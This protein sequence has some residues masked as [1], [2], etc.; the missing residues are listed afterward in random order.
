MSGP[1][2]A[3]EKG[4]NDALILGQAEG[5]FLDPNLTLHL[6]IDKVLVEAEESSKYSPKFYELQLKNPI[7]IENELLSP[8]PVCGFQFSFT[9]N[10][11]VVQFF[12]NISPHV[13][14]LCEFVNSGY[15]VHRNGSIDFIVPIEQKAEPF[16]KCNESVYSAG[17]ELSPDIYSKKY[18]DRFFEQLE[19]HFYEPKTRHSIYKYNNPLKYISRLYDLNEESFQKYLKNYTKLYQEKTITTPIIESLYDNTVATQNKSNAEELANLTCETIFHD[20]ESEYA[21]LNKTEAK[22]CKEQ[23]YLDY[24]KMNKIH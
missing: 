22:T 14:Q 20:Q 1:E 15:Y 4:L 21:Y 23:A 8:R 7:I 13:L 12:C 17:V 2:V 11:S 10:A 5:L 24:A 16:L 9:Q 3:L 6:A 18:S 19:R